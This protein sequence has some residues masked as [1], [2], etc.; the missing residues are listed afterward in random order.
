MDNFTKKFLMSWIGA[1]SYLRSKKE[2][3]LVKITLFK[4]SII[5]NSYI[6]TT[7]KKLILNFF[8]F[9]T[10]QGRRFNANCNGNPPI[11]KHRRYFG[12]SPFIEK[13]A[14]ICTINRGIP[15]TKGQF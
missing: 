1:V 6:C 3:S 9:K 14:H 8:P 15:D 11:R 5:K 10:C 2:V 4:K 7:D 12:K 13:K